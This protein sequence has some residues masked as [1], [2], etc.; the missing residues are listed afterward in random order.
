MVFLRDSEYDYERVEQSVFCTKNVSRA[1]AG[2]FLA[3]APIREKDISKQFWRQQKTPK[4][5]EEIYG[6]WFKYIYNISYLCI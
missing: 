3:Y 2:W 1:P 6:I 4:N 5:I